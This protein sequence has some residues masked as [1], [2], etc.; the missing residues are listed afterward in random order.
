M[1]TF[2]SM[3]N[4]LFKWYY[5]AVYYCMSAIPKPT[6]STSPYIT[7]ESSHIC[8]PNKQ[9]IPRRLS[10]SYKK[11]QVKAKTETQ[12]QRVNPMHLI[13]KCKTFTHCLI[14]F[15]TVQI[16]VQIMSSEER[17]VGE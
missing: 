5:R 12:T 10:V 11:W 17:R 8:I 2:S 14:K 15:L 1:I 4:S 16:S 7:H 13:I 9:R 3:Y 6:N